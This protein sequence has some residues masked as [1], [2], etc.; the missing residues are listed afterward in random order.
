M[1]SQ[2]PTPQFKS[3]NSSALSRLVIPFLPRSKGFFHFVLQSLATVLLEHKKLKSSNISTFPHLFA[4]SNGTGCHDFS[5]LNA[6]FQ[7]SFFT[8]LKKLFNPLQ[9]LPLE[10]YHLHT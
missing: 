4:C 3:I 6:E 2:E 5:F 8:L 7:A 9:F 10:W 1:D